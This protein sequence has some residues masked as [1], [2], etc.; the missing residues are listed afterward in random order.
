MTGIPDRWK[1]AVAQHKAE[2]RLAD[3][4]I[5]AW[6]PETVPTDSD[7]DALKG[8]TKRLLFCVLPDGSGG[9][10][11]KFS[12]RFQVVEWFVFPGAVI[13]KAFALHEVKLYETQM[14]GTVESRHEQMRVNSARVKKRLPYFPV[15]P[16]GKRCVIVCY[17]PSLAQTWV[18]IAGERKYQDATI[19]TVSGAHDF[20][21]ARGIVPDYHVECDPRE[22]KAVFTKTPHRGVRYLL[23]SC[24]HPSLVE[25]LLDYDLSLFHSNNGEE[26]VGLI[27]E[28]EPDG[29][30]INGGG[31]VAFRA[32]YAMHHKGY[33]TFSIYGMDF[34]FRS[35]GT[36]HAGSHPNERQVGIDVKCGARWFL[37]SPNMA[38][39]VRQFIGPMGI[40]QAL[41]DSEFFL[42]G[43][44]LMQHAGR[45]GQGKAA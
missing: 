36:Q 42:H 40:V 14:A 16:H 35:D 9:L 20:M 18:G 3:D 41:S 5:E 34:S 44:G 4:E 19:V 29:V 13:C 26:D 12:E 23:A 10:Q 43:D 30:L 33:R 45:I 27:R 38:R 2:H 32:I 8:R 1:D 37:T 31:S 6:F 15:E 11:E 21:I 7:L 28:I 24:V 17:G 22:H 25:N 39:F